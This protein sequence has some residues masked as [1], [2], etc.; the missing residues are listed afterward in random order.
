MSVHPTVRPPAP[1]HTM[2]SEAFWSCIWFFAHRLF[3]QRLCHVVKF[4][5]FQWLSFEWIFLQNCRF[6]KIDIRLQKDFGTVVIKVRPRVWCKARREAKHRLFC[7]APTQLCNYPDSSFLYMY[8]LMLKR[9]KIMKQNQNHSSLNKLF[10]NSIRQYIKW[11]YRIS[12]NN[13]WSHY[14]N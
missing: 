1:T 2:G 3:H 10:L 13:V 6:L 12:L 4:S 11:T 8:L 5:T 7:S 14:V 9:D